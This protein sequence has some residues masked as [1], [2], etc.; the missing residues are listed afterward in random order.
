MHNAPLDYLALARCQVTQGL[1][2]ALAQAIILVGGSFYFAL[3]IDQRINSTFLTLN[4]LAKASEGRITQSMAYRLASGHFGM[5]S[6][7]TLESLCDIF[8]ITD[9]NPLFTLDRPSVG[10]KSVRRS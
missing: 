6:N 8:G 4:G 3:D 5:V 2:D 10:Q 7:T 1:H 9:P